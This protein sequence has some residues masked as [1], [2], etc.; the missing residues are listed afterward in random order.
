MTQHDPFISMRHM[1]D[2]ASEAISLLKDK[3]LEELQADRVLQ[4][5][6]VQLIEIVG[7][8]ANRVPAEIRN[9]HAQVPWRLASETRNKLIHGY[10]VI[11]YSIVYD[12]VQNDLPPLVKLLDEVLD[13]H[14]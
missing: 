3:A 12:T 4:L 13:E 10:D 9:A 7:E 5:A 11:E 1:R 6:L 2:H 8:A 14:K